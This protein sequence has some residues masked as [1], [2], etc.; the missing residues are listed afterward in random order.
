MNPMH[1]VN[2]WVDE[3]MIRV[4]HL[5]LQMQRLRL[6]ILNRAIAPE[7]SLNLLLCRS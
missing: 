7:D 6:I 5:K 3:E 2:N 4:N 1:V